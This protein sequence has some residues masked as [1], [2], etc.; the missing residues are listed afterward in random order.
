M[1]GL[2]GEDSWGARPL[3]QYQLPYKSRT[4]TFMMIPVS[5]KTINR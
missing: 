1:M 2:G 4:F 5:G 3:N